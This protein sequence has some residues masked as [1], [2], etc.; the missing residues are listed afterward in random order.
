MKCHSPE[1]T[2][3]YILPLYLTPTSLTVTPNPHHN[4][5][6]NPNT[7]Y[8]SNN[9]THGLDGQHQEVDR[10]PSGTVTRS[11]INE[12][13]T[14]MDWPTLGS[15]TAKKQ[16]RTVDSNSISLNSDRKAAIRD[17]A[18]REEAGRPARGINVR[19]ATA[20]V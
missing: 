15:R 14:S 18:S 17:G 9:P 16:S 11:G 13:S 3:E 19:Q 2:A 7:G 8:V 6:H 12:E 1:I 4:P 20:S 5:H 10:T